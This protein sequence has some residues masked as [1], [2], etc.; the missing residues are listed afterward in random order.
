[1]Y[2]SAVAEN[3]PAS[4][5]IRPRSQVMSETVNVESQLGRNGGERSWNVPSIAL[6]TR[7]E[8]IMT[9][10]RW[11][12]SS[13]GQ[14]YVSMTS[15]QTKASSGSVANMLAP[16]CEGSGS[17]RALLSFVASGR[18]LTHARAML[19]SVSSEAKLLRM[20]PCVLSV[21]TRNPDVDMHRQAT[22]ESAVLTWVTW[23]KRSRVGVRSEP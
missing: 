19:M 15:R 18:G 14:K 7:D 16:N 1:M 13:P 10:R 2:A 6:N 17:A 3:P 12:K 5:R 21:K 22:T 23:A 9:C 8:V 11:L 20:L 4:S